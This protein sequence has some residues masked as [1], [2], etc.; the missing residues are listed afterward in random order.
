MSEVSPLISKRLL[1]LVKTLQQKLAKYIE[2]MNQVPPS[3]FEYFYILPTPDSLV[4]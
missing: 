3:G 4:A 1:N 2:K